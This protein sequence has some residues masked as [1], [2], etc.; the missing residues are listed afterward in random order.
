MSDLD[1]DMVMLD[2]DHDMVMLG[3]DHAWYTVIWLC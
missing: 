2:L 3:L 1:H